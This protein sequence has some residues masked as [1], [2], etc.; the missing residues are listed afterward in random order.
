MAGTLG[1]KEHGMSSL[2]FPFPSYFPS[3]AGVSGKPKQNLKNQWLQAGKSPNKRL[4]SQLKDQNT[5][6][7]PRQTTY[8]K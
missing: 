1:S 6:S 2:S 8:T 4:L 5:G 7:L 3:G